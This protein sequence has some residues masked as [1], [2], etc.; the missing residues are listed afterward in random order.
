MF[1]S[2]DKNNKDKKKGF[3][4]F[5]KTQRTYVALAVCA[6]ILG[7]AVYFAV[8]S[9]GNGGEAEDAQ[10][11]QAPTL[12]EEKSSAASPSKSATASSETTID[13]SP[14]MSEQTTDVDTSA[15]PSNSGS[16]QETIVYLTMPV[17]D[18]EI[19]QEFSKEVMVFN[20]T[21]NMWAT[22]NGI[23]ISAEA[24]DTIVAAL[25][26]TVS[27]VKKDN[28]MGYVVEI[29]HSGGQVTRYAGLSK[30]TVS[31]GDKVNAGQSIGTVGIPAFEAHLG[32]HL[33]FEYLV[34]DKYVDPVSK[35]KS[36]GS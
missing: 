29:E 26:G 7:T 17:A 31:S 24:G 19:I 4:N 10:H 27:S 2:F 15:S 3:K 1:N 32:T 11:Q 8:S 20:Q 35:L 34:N 28:T 22:H 6:L 18:G 25:A 23:D 5:L 12:E 14:E 33:H 30:T 13:A 36:S 9:S 21:L 16:K